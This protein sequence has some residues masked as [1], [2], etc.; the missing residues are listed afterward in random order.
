VQRSDA[1]VV[2]KVFGV[3]G[4]S[5]GFDGGGDD[6]GVVEAVLGL[7]MDFQGMYPDCHGWVDTTPGGEQFL[8]K[9]CHQM[10]WNL[11]LGMMERDAA[12]FLNHLP[13]DKPVLTAW[14][15]GGCFS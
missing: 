6:E 15:L 3:E 13:T 12:E 10:V 11:M 5:A 8:D 14:R 1:A 4:F 7:V 2:L 9:R